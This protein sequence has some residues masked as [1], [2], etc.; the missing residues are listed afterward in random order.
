MKDNPMKWHPDWQAA[1]EA[2]KQRKAVSEPFSKILDGGRVL[3]VCI[4]MDARSRQPEYTYGTCPAIKVKGLDRPRASE[5]D[6]I[7]RWK[8][9]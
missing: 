5:V 2:C 1:A 8:P 6:A 3:N 9:W 7:R 4:V